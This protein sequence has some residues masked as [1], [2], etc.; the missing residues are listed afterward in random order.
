MKVL[1][2]DSM[3]LLYRGHYA[4]IKRPLRASDGTV[5]SGLH[6]LL[7][8]IYRHAD[9]LEPDLL[10]VV[11]DHPGPTFRTGMYGEYKANRPETPEELV[12][13]SRLARSLVDSLGL[14]RVE[15]EGLE[16]DD[17]IAGLARTAAAAGH[18]V[19]VVS[20]DKDLLQV[21]E[22]GV[23]VIQPGRPGREARSV[24]A[25]D[26]PD[27]LGVEVGQV[28]DYM[29]LVG[30]SSDNIPGAKGIGPKTA[31]KLLAKWG[32]LDSIYENL[33]RVGPAGTREKLRSQRDS[34]MLSRSLVGLDYSLPE[35]VCL[36]DLRPSA[37]RV[38][39]ATRLL[40]RL[41]MRTV[42]DRL[43]KGE[44]AGCR[45]DLVDTTEA[46][47][48][49]VEELSVCGELA[50]DTETDSPDPME[51]RPVG[52][53]LAREGDS[54]W[55]LPLRGE[56]AL[57]REEAVSAL[58]TISSGCSMVAQNAKYDMHVLR[59]MGVDWRAVGG[60]PFLADYLLRPGGSRRSLAA[61]SRLYLGR[62]MDT[63]DQVLDGAGTLL[64]VPLEKV[65]AYCCA[66][67]TTALLLHRKLSGMLAEAPELE[68]IYRTVELPL[69]EVLTDME[70][71]GVSLD[72]DSL[73]QLRGE[74][75]ARLA[76]LAEEAADI[77]GRP[78]NLNSPQ[79]VSEV[80]F[81][82]LGLE[83]VRKTSTGRPSSSMTV[84]RTLQGR[85]RFVDLVI[86]HR[87]LSK[88][89]STYIE[90]L[91]D[92]V[93]PSTGLIHTSFN[94]AVTA[95]GR[96]SSSS[97]N[98][99][100]IP[101]RTARGRSI[102][103]CFAPPG[104]GEVFVSADYSQIELRVLAHLAGDG[105]LREAYRKGEDI[106]SRTARSVFG[107]DAPEM[108]RR[109]KE[110][111][112]SIVYGISPYGLASRLGVSRG[113][114]A[115]IINRYFDTYPEVES[116]FRETVASAET[117]GETRTI[118]GRRRDF[119]G[120]AGAGGSNR[121]AMERMAV[122]TTVQGSAADIMKL[123]MIAVH[124]R[125]AEELPEAGL[126]LQVHDELLLSVDAESADEATRIMVEEMESAAE[127]A[128]PLEVETGTGSDW[129]EAQH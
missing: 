30:D 124:R 110:V 112:F 82:D 24:E 31:V 54:A 75:S 101:I 107:D 38:E 98:L 115:G 36:E 58:R 56:G 35:G 95:T 123:A 120:L 65:S 77:A 27:I 60:D 79:Q 48:R 3:G 80:L 119:S 32:S 72:L 26:V 34:V 78:I 61:L 14:P 22:E 70:R 1:L 100:N 13:Q 57:P 129:M 83:T 53:A 66:D 84:L 97:P 59:G 5:T 122:N 121:R 25:G 17:L 8:E 2:I 126:V 12:V 45:V 105:A 28:P 108:R 114:A 103:R 117:R 52:L 96:L 64:E 125:L 46:L 93:S 37:P 21:L 104:E 94:Q 88:L 4:L 44:S 71:R 127:L 7:G 118:L 23:T 20:S 87:E 43:P 76:E 116:F 49:L 109:A 16:A 113:E 73:E 41:G 67:V 11:F 74:Y 42:L 99:Q 90:K 50:V 55:Y 47:G 9:A 128:V 18:S 15:A 69:V 62:D 86:E 10:G 68:E 106:H 63:Y 111:N 92:F 40:S 85:H 39:E 6:H 33:E 51:A 19:T 91:P 89:L 81:E 102:R 29:A